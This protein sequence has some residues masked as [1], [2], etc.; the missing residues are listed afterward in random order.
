[1]RSKYWFLKQIKLF[2]ELEK[3]DLDRLNRVTRMEDIKRRQLIYLPGDA[4]D[5][6][7]LLKAGRVKI[8]RVNDEGKELI[9]AIMDPG[10]VFG[11]LEVLDSSPRDTIAEALED[12]SVCVMRREDFVEVLKKNPDLTYR[13]TKLIGFKLKKIENRIEDLV[14]SDVPVRLAHLLMNLSNE[15]GQ[16]EDGGIRLNV[17]ITHQELANLIGSTRETV[18]ATLSDFKRRGFILQD[19]RTIIIQDSKSLGA[20]R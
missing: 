13:L 9:L 20:L 5:T 4:P 17:R 3:Q 11:E 7:Y 16:Q 2:S 15:F 19:H 6:V 14:F 1:M 8:S 18:S 12:I 10:E